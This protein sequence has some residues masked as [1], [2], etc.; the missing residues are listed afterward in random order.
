MPA[1]SA[2]FRFVYVVSGTGSVFEEVLRAIDAGILPA[3]IAGVIA[4]RPCPAAERSRSRGLPT[5]VVNVADFGRREDFDA[6]IASAIEAFA[7][8]G[9]AVNCNYL[10]PPAVTTP[11]QNRI[12]NPHFTLLPLFP[13]FGPIRQTLASGMR[14]AGVT[15]H[16]VD[17][18]VD[19]GPI[20]A[21]AVRPVGPGAT[22]ASLGRS[23]FSI[24]A[25]LFIQALRF[26]VEGR[27]AVSHRTAAVRQAD[28][29]R[30]PCIPAL[31][32]DI[33]ALA[34]RLEQQPATIGID[35]QARRSE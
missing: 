13:G 21:Q 27:I 10:L 3:T 33:A 31:E 4:D 1:R 34:V 20:V 23:L 7:P 35:L 6:A 26:L 2:P 12:L 29:S 30:L 9:I 22:A 18:T 17:D 16:L 14:V 25:P 24:G 19:G 28:Y 32:P 8:D 11:Y 15:V 5:R